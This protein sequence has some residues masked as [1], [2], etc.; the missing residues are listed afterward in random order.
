MTN[1][2]DY[3]ISLQPPFL[4]FFLH[5][6]LTAFTNRFGDY[7]KLNTYLCRRLKK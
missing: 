6:V 2:I 1:N 3:K 5:F 4:Y 7:K